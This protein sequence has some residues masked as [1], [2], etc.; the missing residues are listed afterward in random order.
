VRCR[1]AVWGTRGNGISPRAAGAS[2]PA[3]LRDGDQHSLPSGDSV[4]PKPT[5]L[6]LRVVLLPLIHQ[7]RHVRPVNKGLPGFF[8]QPS[9]ICVGARVL[10]ILQ[11]LPHELPATANDHERS[12]G[13][14]P[15]RERRQPRSAAPPAFVACTRGEPAARTYRCRAFEYCQRARSTVRIGSPLRRASSRTYATYPSQNGIV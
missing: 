12:A 15:R 14:Q 8:R 2:R 5:S 11:K 3:L 4:D 13:P 7:P 10:L 6:P 1:R 9:H